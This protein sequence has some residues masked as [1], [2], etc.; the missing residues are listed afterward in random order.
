MT[1][2]TYNPEKILILGSQIDLVDFED[3][4]TLMKEWI[5]GYSS[6]AP[7]RRIVVTGFH[8]IFEAHKNPDFKSVLNSADLWVPDG[9]APVWIARL[10]GNR[11]VVRTP[12]AEIMQAYFK[13]ADENG[14]SSFFY[15]DTEETL[16]NLKRRLQ[17]DYPGHTI[18]GVFSPP[19]R[20]LTETE[21]NNIIQMINNS[22]PDVLWVALGM[23]KQDR[24]IFEH[25]DRLRVPI[26][27]GVGAA[28]SFISGDVKRVPEWI[29]R[30]GLEW[31]W[32]L[33][34]EPK[35]LWKR[36]FVDGPMFL[37]NVFLE[38]TGLRKYG[39]K[40]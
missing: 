40:S 1:D 14:Y 13:L 35:K 4:T 38:L 25:L 27:V 9:I 36:D 3:T 22:R 21:D 12:G 18:A 31:L 28:F 10:K 16:A 11:G 33:S 5:D 15:G 37:F 34:R 39:S 26:A 30:F 2:Y 19:F 23:P 8:G 17:A 24:W 32:R 29:G 6:K 20:S 7:C